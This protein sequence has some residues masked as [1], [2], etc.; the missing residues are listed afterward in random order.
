M[1]ISTERLRRAVIDY[2]DQAL[3]MGIVEAKIDIE[4][5]EKA[6]QEELIEIAKEID[7]D[8]DHFSINNAK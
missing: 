1:Q 6:D 2:F 8:V 7:I 4:Q 5:A 3:E